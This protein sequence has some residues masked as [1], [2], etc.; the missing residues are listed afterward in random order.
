MSSSLML[1][2]FV[3]QEQ[4]QSNEIAQPSPIAYQYYK[5]HEQEVF[6]ETSNYVVPVAHS[7]PPKYSS[8]LTKCDCCPFNYHIDL[9]FIRYCE[10]LAANGKRSSTRQ[11]DRRN[12]R[13]QRKSLEVMLGF[14]DQWVLDIGKELLQPT[15]QQ[16]SKFQTVYEVWISEIFLCFRII[17]SGVTWEGWFGVVTDYL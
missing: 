1:D 17:V 14:E 4:H 7:S 2:S 13:L 15:K 12:K 3:I 6:E 5:T 11:L 8:K 9:D 16:K 10:E